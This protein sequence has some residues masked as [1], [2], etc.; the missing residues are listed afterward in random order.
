RGLTSNDV[1]QS[2]VTE[3]P[4][5]APNKYIIVSIDTCSGMIV[6]TAGRKQNSKAITTHWE[7]AIAWLGIPRMIKT[8][9]GLGFVAK[10]T[11]AWAEK[12]QIEFRQSIPYNCK[13]Q[14]IVE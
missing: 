3:Y 10:E 6:A 5:F 7:T 9:N 11:R 12:W 1:W 8:D 13:G 2:D 14:G 4:C